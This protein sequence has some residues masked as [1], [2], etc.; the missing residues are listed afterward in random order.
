MLSFASYYLARE[1]SKQ[2]IGQFEALFKLSNAICENLEA[3]FEGHSSK[4]NNCLIVGPTGSGKTEIARALS[5]KFSI[6]FAKVSITDYTLTGYRGKDPHEIVTVDFA[7]AVKDNYR[8]IKRLA[9]N[10]FLYKKALSIFCKSEI[11]PEKRK[12]AFEYAAARVF[13]VNRKVLELMYERFNGTEEALKTAS[14]IE[15]IAAEIDL[16]PGSEEREDDN[17]PTSISFQKRPFGLIFIDE[18]DK[19]LINERGYDEDGFYRNLQYHLLELIEGGSVRADKSSD[20]IDTSHITFILAGAFTEASPE[21]FVPELKGRLNV[22]INVKKLEYEDYLTIINCKLQDYLLS[23]NSKNS[24]NSDSSLPEPVVIE[25]SGKIEL[26]KICAEENEKEYLGARRLN[27][28]MSKIREA[29]EWELL[30]DSVFPV[31]VDASFVKWALETDFSFQLPMLPE[32]NQEEREKIR[33]ICLRGK[34]PKDNEVK[35]RVLVLKAELEKVQ[36]GDPGSLIPQNKLVD[37]LLLRDSKG[38]TVLE[39]LIEDGA[40]SYLSLT[41]SNFRLIKRVISKELLEKITI[42]VLGGT[43]KSSDKNEISDKWE[44][45]DID[46]EELGKLIEEMEDYFNDESS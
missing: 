23:E 6:P 30:H 25:N 11:S 40:V 17:F 3:Y 28:L 16:F 7:P 2:V 42:E 9:E 27:T 31:V 45:I 35:A 10:Y 37:F 32:I 5:R 20:L 1:L 4:K 36:S 14:L 46:C 24:G 38:K 26:A 15:E 41:K 29:V 13:F 22:R 18:A 44:E 34:V 39:Y 33:D 21:E 19:L 43:K 12:V 8:E